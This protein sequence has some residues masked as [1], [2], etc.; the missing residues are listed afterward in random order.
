MS[1]G[2]RGVNS[3]TTVGSKYFPQPN[4]GF[5]CGPGGSSPER[6]N[7]GLADPIITRDRSYCLY[8]NINTEGRQWPSP[9]RSLCVL[10]LWLL[11]CLRV[12]FIWGG[13]QP[14]AS[15]HVKLEAGGQSH[16]PS[17][18]VSSPAAAA[19]RPPLCGFAGVPR[20]RGAGTWKVLPLSWL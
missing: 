6:P 19:T 17:G 16:L 3:W 1:L 12:G 11:Q 9:A 14:C 18:L 4:P 20:E 15:S 2:T 10:G 8:T 5:H 13:F 7:W